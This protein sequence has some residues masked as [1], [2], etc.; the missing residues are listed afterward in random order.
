[1]PEY[2]NN[3]DIPLPLVKG[4]NKISFDGIMVKAGIEKM[5]IDGVICKTKNFIRIY[6]NEH[7]LI[8]SLY[9]QPF[10]QTELTSSITLKLSDK[11]NVVSHK[12]C[13]IILIGRGKKDVT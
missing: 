3:L 2:Q 12:K 8:Y 10:E 13:N 4:D 9:L 5:C 7:Q 11:V 1:M 6:V